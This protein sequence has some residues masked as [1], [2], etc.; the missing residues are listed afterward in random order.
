MRVI[1]SSQPWRSDPSVARMPWRTED[2]AFLGGKDKPRIGVLRHDGVCLP[3]PPMVRALDQAVTKLRAAGYDVVDVPPP[4]PGCS[5]TEGWALLRRLY[6][7]DGGA[8]V[9]NLAAAS[10]E[11]ILPLTEWVLSAAKDTP[12]TELFELTIKRDNFRAAYNAY[13]NELGIDA[14]LAPPY[15]GPAPQLGTSKYWMYTAMWNLVDYPGATFPTPWSVEADDVAKKREYLSDDD[16]MIA[17]FCE[18]DG[19]APLL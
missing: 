2:V 3:Q 8:R 15:P 19:V 18:W 4:P 17:E 9:R 12:A 16:K 10:G 14:L 11:P 1:L 6:F 5:V 7:T 13:W